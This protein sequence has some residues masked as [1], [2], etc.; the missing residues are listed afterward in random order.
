MRNLLAESLEVSTT[1]HYL[2]E[3]GSRSKTP[4]YD[5]VIVAIQLSEGVRRIY[6]I[7]RSSFV[8]RKDLPHTHSHSISGTTYHSDSDYWF[9]ESGKKFITYKDDESFAKAIKSIQKKIKG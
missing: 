2:N 1:S 5:M 7:H 6:Q 3:D 8:G 4:S 9:R